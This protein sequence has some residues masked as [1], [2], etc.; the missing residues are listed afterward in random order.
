MFL[1]PVRVASD[2]SSEASAEA[3]ADPA[4]GSVCGGHELAGSGDHPG[5]SFRGPCLRILFCWTLSQKMLSREPCLK[6]TVFRT[7]S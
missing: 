6:D 1:F 2:E 4:Q 5:A 3:V 7:L